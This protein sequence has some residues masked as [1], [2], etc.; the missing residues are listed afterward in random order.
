MSYRIFLCLFVSLYLGANYVSPARAGEMFSTETTQSEDAVFAFFR[1][2]NVPPDYDEWIKG[3]HTYMSL[4]LSEQNN[5]LLQETLRLGH[6]YAEYNPERD[7]LKVDVPVVAKLI[8]PKDN[9]KARF[10]FEFIHNDNKSFTPTFAYPYGPH[11]INMVIN[12]LAL[13]SNFSLTEKQYLSIKERLSRYEEGEEMD[14]LLKLRIK[15]VQADYNSPISMGDSGLMWLM[16][17]EIGYLSCVQDSFFGTDKIQ[18]WDYLAPW[19]EEQ[20]NEENR[21]EEEKYPHPYDLYKD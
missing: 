16:V 7:L 4:P 6:G 1:V 2:A 8:P 12:K 21:S 20:Y 11:T 3:S 18:L 19:Y 13:F 14:V 10:I 15:I 17:G 5:Y 9:K